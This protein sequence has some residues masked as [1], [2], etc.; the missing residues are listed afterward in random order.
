MDM[1]A[2]EINVLVKDRW[3]ES[4]HD[5]WPVSNL[6]SMAK[7]KTAFNLLW[8]LLYYLEQRILLFAFAMFC[9]YNVLFVTIAGAAAF[10]SEG[11][12]KPFSVTNDFGG[13]QT[14]GNYLL[15]HLLSRDKSPI[16]VTTCFSGTPLPARR[17]SYMALVWLSD[18]HFLVWIISS[19][20]FKSYVNM[21]TYLTAKR[22]DQ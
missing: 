2:E 10:S 12:G 8:P 16:L 15:V 5:E 14:L 20:S 7:G 9:T 6:L 4:L 21:C 1:W 22:L 3:E 18:I 19:G 11:K 17:S 13:R